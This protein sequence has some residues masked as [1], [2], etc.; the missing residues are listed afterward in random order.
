MMQEKIKVGVL[1][2]DMPDMVCFRLRVLDPLQ[3]MGNYLEYQIYQQMAKRMYEQSYPYSDDDEFVSAMDIFIVQRVFPVAE[4]R[5]LLQKILDSGKPVI[6]ELDDWFLGMPESHKQFVL[7]EPCFPHVEWMLKNASLVV[8]PT[9]TLAEKVKLYNSRCFIFENAISRQRWIEPI[10]KNGEQVIIG[11]AGTAT[12]EREVRMINE[13]LMRIHNDY[14]GRVQF[15]MWGSCPPGL[16]GKQDVREIEQYVSYARYYKK[17]ASLRIDIGLAPLATGAFSECKSDLKWIDYS[18]TGACAV[19]SDV[20]SYTW[21]GNK[22][23]ASVVPNDT[24]SWYQAIAKLIEDPSLRQRHHAAS[25]EYVR[26]QR[27]LEHTVHGYYD[28]IRQ[29]LPDAGLPETMQELAAIDLRQTSTLYVEDDKPYTRWVDVH[30]MREIHAEQ[31]AERMVLAWKKRPV[32]NLVVIVPQTRLERLSESMTALQKQLYPHWHLIVVSDAPVPDPIFES[33]NQLA[34]VCLENLA[35]A[36]LVS[37]VLNQIA[38]EVPAD[39]MWLLPSGFQLSPDALLRVAEACHQHPEWKA[40]YCDSDIISPMGSRFLPEFR[41]DFSP[42]FLRSMDYIGHSAIFSQEVISRLGGFQPYPDAYSYDLMLRLIEQVPC[43][44]VGHIDDI[45]LSSPW[46][47]GRD[48]SVGLAARQVALENH[49]KRC[50]FPVR[51]GPGLVDGTFHYEYQILQRSL[52]S[53][54]IPNKDKLEYLEPCIES[55]FAKT[56]YDNFELII[57]ENRSELPE[58]FDYYQKIQEV[59]PE[60]V[61]IINYDAPFNFSAQCNLGVSIA[62][63]DYVLLLNNDTEIVQAQW[64]ERMLATAQQPGVGAVGARL[65]FPGALTVQHAGIVLGMPGGLFSAA[66]HVFANAPIDE[67]GYMNRILTMQNYSAV[68]AACLLVE[69][70]IYQL[71]GGMDE[72]E[73]KVCFNDVDFCL[74][75]QKQ[76]L[77]NVYNPYSVVVHHHARSLNVR[78]TDPRIALRAMERERN[79]LENFIAKWVSALKHDPG[80]NRHLSLQGTTVSVSSGRSAA[81]APDVP[82]RLRVLGMPVPGGSGEYRLSQPMYALQQHGRLDGEILQ[83]DQGVLSI[84]EMA[85]LAPDILLLHTGVQDAVIDA[86]E[87]YRR[88]LPELRIVFGLDDLIGSLPEKSSLSEHWRRHYPDAK[89]RLRKVLASCH[90]LV[91]STEPLADFARSMISNISVVPNRLR[92]DIWGGLSSLRR[93]GNKPR[94]GWVGAAQHRGDLELIFEVIK[95]THEEVDWIF[96]GMCLPQFRPYVAEVHPFVSFEEYPSKVASLNLDLAVAPLEVNAFN[97]A[98]S[99]LRLLE[100]GAMG[101]PVICTDIFPYQTNL[102]PVCRLP[103]DSKRWIEEIRARVHDLDAAHREGDELNAWVKRYYWLEEHLDDWEH[104]LAGRAVK[105]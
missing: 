76:G 2:R 94:V 66:D 31:L 55:L 28:Q 103:N 9:I 100:Y 45:L 71:V 87:A 63:G 81:W 41:P 18:L 54:V 85:R 58:T 13:A 7:F 23:M 97:E 30:Q 27:Q 24:E 44:Q 25:A 62:R 3:L 52:V 21:L 91:V 56:E 59:W 78:T 51:V 33:G 74:K 10:P 4:S 79:E 16:K 35:D 34:W 49:A 42:D 37:T 101:W 39:W 43:S 105:K 89:A 8:V 99:N 75:I 73:F 67:P 46:E 22:D 84:A 40:V 70:Q 77:R 95:Q 26:S 61:R 50:G 65:M 64:L 36:Q 90:E 92:K 48:H 72:T 86:I 88:Y 14:A 69:K 57:V 6:Y 1:T 102:A 5:A 83:P 68:T 80:Y 47:G 19:V 17:L 60:R 20:G 15:V 53:I 11:I 12:R 29:L 38:A 82:S 32:F 96:M 104:A 98:K 93:Q